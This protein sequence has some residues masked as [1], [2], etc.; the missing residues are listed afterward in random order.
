L[1]RRDHLALAA[2]EA[3]R[4]LSFGEICFILALADFRPIR[5]K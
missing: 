4:D 3:M 1:L 5:E 2:C